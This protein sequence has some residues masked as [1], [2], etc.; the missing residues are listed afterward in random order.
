MLLPSTTCVGRSGS[1]VASCSGTARHRT[2]NPAMVLRVWRH[3]IDVRCRPG[4]QQSAPIA[5]PRASCAPTASGC[6]RLQLAKPE[7][8]RACERASVAAVPQQQISRR[9]TYSAPSQQLQG[10]E[11]VHIVGGSRPG[12]NEQRM[13]ARGVSCRCVPGRRISIC[14]D[15]HAC[16]AAAQV[17][18]LCACSCPGLSRACST[19][20]YPVDSMEGQP[21]TRPYS[22]QALGSVLCRSVARRVRTSPF[23]NKLSSCILCGTR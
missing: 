5:A 19:A 22:C 17:H 18:A 7:A 2:Q 21:R 15:S 6:K 16:H 1:K 4:P 3:H 14:G 8:A 11:P 12:I 9:S 10:P 20:A 13:I 23:T